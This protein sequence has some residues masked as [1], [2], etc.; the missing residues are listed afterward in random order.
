MRKR[1]L[2]EL[3]DPQVTGAVF[4]RDHSDISSLSGTQSMA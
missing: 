2:G 1:C 4:E 3:Y